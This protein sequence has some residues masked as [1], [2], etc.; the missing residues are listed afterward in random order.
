MLFRSI[1]SARI[2]LVPCVCVGAIAT[3]SG[4]RA[5]AQRAPDAGAD[6]GAV[7]PS[8]SGPR[9]PVPGSPSV[10]RPTLVV[11]RSGPRR[12]QQIAPVPPA[13]QPPAPMRFAFDTVTREY[14]MT[15]TSAVLSRDGAFLAFLRGGR[16]MVRHLETNAET[17][18]VTGR[19]GDGTVGFIGWSPRD[20]SVAYTLAVQQR[21]DGPDRPRM[22][23]PEGTYVAS[24][25]ATNA[26]PAGRPPRASLRAETRRMTLP[27]DVVP[28]YWAS[29]EADTFY[30][31]QHVAQYHEELRR[32]THANPNPRTLFTLR[33][34]YWGMSQFHLR[35]NALVFAH[36]AVS[37][38]Q[39]TEAVT[40][41][42]LDDRALALRPLSTERLLNAGAEL[43]PDGT[44][45]LW[46]APDNAPRSVWHAPFDGRAR[47]RA[48]FRCAGQC[49][50]RWESSTTM[51]VVDNGALHRV[52]I[53]GQPPVTVVARDVEVVI[54]AGGA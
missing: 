38:P 22:P 54:V 47:A 23:A 35:G 51:F 34:G 8:A 43:S 6:A 37:A 13:G 33:G 50:A 11:L 9:A 42:R 20:N 12:P 45:V 7:A 49:W 32:V 52:F 36:R 29:D 3:Y 30:Y 46:H 18:L 19:M 15:P 44:Q 2:V 26:A 24:I 41:V 31:V 4:S 21:L 16:P 27:A 14:A 39:N 53:D 5:L 17:P 28:V 1:S 40:A 10:T 25:V 48:V